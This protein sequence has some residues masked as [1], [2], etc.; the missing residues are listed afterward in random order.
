MKNT[1]TKYKPMEEGDR[2]IEES[3]WPPGVMQQTIQRPDGTDYA[4]VV[5]PGEDA[6]A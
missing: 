4:R 2:I 6:D 1:D 3:E 5:L